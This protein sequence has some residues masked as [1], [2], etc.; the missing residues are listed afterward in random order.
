MRS[1]MA[2][3]ERL[4]AAEFGEDVVDHRTY[5]ICGDGCLME[6]ISHEALSLA[7]HLRLRKLIVLWDDNSISIDGPTSLAVDDDQVARFAAHGWATDR[8]DGHD[9]DAVAAAIKKR[10]ATTGRR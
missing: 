3:A 2:L 1:G 4:L 7:G 9:H 8:V 6:G 5:A 10:R